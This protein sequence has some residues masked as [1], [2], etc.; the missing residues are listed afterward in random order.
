MRHLSTIM[1]L[2]KS[3]S[4]P[5]CCVYLA[6]REFTI[7]WGWQWLW[8]VLKFLRC[9][10]F[11]RCKQHCS[12]CNLFCKW[13]LSC[14]FVLWVFRF[15]KRRGSSADILMLRLPNNLVSFR[16]GL[17]CIKCS[18]TKSH[19]VFLSLS[20]LL[21]W[22]VFSWQ[23]LMNDI[24]V[25]ILAFNVVITR[26]VSEI[27]SSLVDGIVLAWSRRVLATARLC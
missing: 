2:S 17:R 8:S 27:F 22:C 18:T 14:F 25:T 19:F 21:L 4:C 6:K 7:D 24:W 26:C 1:T 12:H 5:V 20:G 23:L 16:K 15:F 13:H 11:A 10:M 9:E 3:K